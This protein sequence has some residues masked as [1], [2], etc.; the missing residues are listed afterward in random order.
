MLISLTASGIVPTTEGAGVPRYDLTMG[1]ETDG[2]DTRELDG[3]DDGEGGRDD[4]WAG[5]A[6]RGTVAYSVELGHLI[7]LK[8]SVKLS[9]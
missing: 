3:R 1:V 8:Y 7:T 9:I 6:T 5:D 2:A 4:D